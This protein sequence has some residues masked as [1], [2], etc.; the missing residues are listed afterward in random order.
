MTQSPSRG[1]LLHL[2]WLAVDQFVAAVRG[3]PTLTWLGWP[4][5][6]VAAVRGAPRPAQ[7]ELAGQLRLDVP[8]ACVGRRARP[9]PTYRVGVPPHRFDRRVTLV[10]AELTVP[11]NAGISP[12]RKS[13]VRPRLC[14]HGVVAF[15][16]RGASWGRFRTRAT[17]SQ[18]AALSSSRLT[19]GSHH[20][21][22][23]D[24]NSRSRSARR[25]DLD[26]TIPYTD[27]I[28]DQTRP[29]NLGPLT[30]TLHRA[31]TSRRRQV[32]QPASGIFWW[33]SPHHQHYRVTNHSTDDLHQW[34]T[35]EQG[36]LWR[37]DAQPPPNG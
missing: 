26:H 2:G 18:R 3:R 11:A 32:K 37:R 34:S 9:T 17:G 1:S 6:S 25:L 19:P 15:R 8:F 22:S 28:D 7:A 30:R 12:V 29:D 24:P 31:E 36:L 10:A 13:A 20:A 23:T 35:G 21:H 5:E 16:H 27:G 33:T 14:H 4:G